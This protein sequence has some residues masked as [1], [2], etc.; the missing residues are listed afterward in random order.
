MQGKDSFSSDVFTG[1]LTSSHLAST[2]PRLNKAMEA[3]PL[4]SIPH[5]EPKASAVGL[6]LCSRLVGWFDT[7]GF[8]GILLV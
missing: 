6:I 4:R 8:C 2:K 3:T 1:Q 7:V 5:L